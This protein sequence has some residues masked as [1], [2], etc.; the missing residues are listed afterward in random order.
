MNTYECLACGRKY[1]DDEIKNLRVFFA[2]TTSDGEL[3]RVSCE[4]GHMIE[5][6]RPGFRGK[7]NLK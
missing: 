5:V 7:A 6:H 2:R 3:I 4:C 1:N